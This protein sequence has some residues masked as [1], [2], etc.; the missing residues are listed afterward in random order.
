MFQ[1]NEPFDFCNHPF[2][3]SFSVYL[4]M[5]NKKRHHSI[6]I[7]GMKAHFPIIFPNRKATPKLIAIIKNGDARTIFFI[8]KFIFFLRQ[9]N[10]AT[11]HLNTTAPNRLN[12][13]NR[14]SRI[15]VYPSNSSF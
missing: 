11:Y 15:L 5:K 4:K 7:M 12:Q 14:I 8:D 1:R 10:L 6:K 3:V 2:L 9:D 13:I